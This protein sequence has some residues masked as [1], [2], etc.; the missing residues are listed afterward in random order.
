MKVKEFLKV[1]SPHTIFTIS[2]GKFI[3]E[4]GGYLYTFGLPEGFGETYGEWNVVGVRPHSKN[5]LEV[6]I[7]F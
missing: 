1:C 7:V 2:E 3:N 5:I 4:G 6:A